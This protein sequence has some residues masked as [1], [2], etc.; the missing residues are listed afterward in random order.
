VTPDT[1]KALI[2]RMAEGMSRSYFKRDY[3]SGKR[4]ITMAGNAFS[5]LYRTEEGRKIIDT[6]AELFERTEND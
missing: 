1:K 5:A 3:P 6:Q 2:L 4:L